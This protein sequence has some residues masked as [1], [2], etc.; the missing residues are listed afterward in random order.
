MELSQAAGYFNTVPLA[1]WNGSA[2]V[3]NIAYGDFLTYDR[4]L[5]PRTFGHLQ[6]MFHM[7][8][9][10]SALQAYEVVRSPGGQ[11]YLNASYNHDF[12]GGTEYATSFLLQECLYTV[13]VIDMV[14]TPAPSGL[15]GSVVP[16]VTG[17]FH[18]HKERFT[19]EAS[20]EVDTVRYG[21]FVFQLPLS[22]EA[23]VTVDSELKVEGVHHEVKEVH[24]VLNILEVRAL[25]RG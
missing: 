6:R 10:G 22:A 18:G 23:L 25:E 11:I 9:D 1:G 12:R 3:S 21:T 8:G 16:T 24:R 13:E 7:S 19:S 4:F 14:T 20:S 2:W 15:G 17:T 5:G